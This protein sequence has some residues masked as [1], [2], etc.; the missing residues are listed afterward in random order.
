LLRGLWSIAAVEKNTESFSLDHEDDF[1]KMTTDYDIK[2]FQFENL[3]S[4]QMEIINSCLKSPI[5]NPEEAFFEDSINAVTLNLPY[6]FCE[7]CCYLMTHDSYKFHVLTQSHKNKFKDKV[8]EEISEIYQ[9][10]DLIIKSFK[11]EF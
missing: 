5:L 2:P 1:S 4:D 3:D 8:G 10:I 7:C 11:D 6:T 9:Q